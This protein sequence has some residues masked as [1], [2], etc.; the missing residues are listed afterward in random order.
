MPLVSVIIPSFNH[1]QFIAQ[2]IDSIA[3]QSFSDWELVI[4]DDGS[5]DGSQA[6]LAT[7][8]S[9]KVRVIL[10]ERNHGACHAMNTAIEHARGEYIAVINSDDVAKPHRLERQLAFLESNPQV[11]AVFARPDLIDEAGQP[12]SSESNRPFF[13][14]PKQ[15]RAEWLRYFID[16]TNCLCHPTLLARRQMYELIGGYDNTLVQL[17]D[18][19]MWLRLLRVGAFAVLPE[20]LIDFRIRRDGK[21]VSAPTNE[22]LMRCHVELYWIAKRFFDF[23]DTLLRE[24]FVDVDAFRSGPAKLRLA[25]YLITQNRPYSLL[26]GLDALRAHTTAMPLAADLRNELQRLTGTV[27]PFGLVPRAQIASLQQR[28]SFATTFARR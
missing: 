24:A 12:T 22:A 5:T 1:R 20:P 9:E 10:F 6:L 13:I 26:A 11:L 4:V 15:S 25:E 2:T 23:D 19:D 27:D 17:P 28:P 14:E 16:F 18:F 21:N 7:R 8:K 3:A